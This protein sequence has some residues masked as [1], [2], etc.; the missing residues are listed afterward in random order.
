MKGLKYKNQQNVEQRHELSKCYWKNDTSSLAQCMATTKL[1]FVKKK[2]CTICE[3]Y[4][5]NCN[6]TKYVFMY[7]YMVTDRITEKWK[8]QQGGKWKGDFIL[9]TVP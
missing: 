9:T 2:K 3:A 1:Q 7:T 5:V 8:L 4:K 6:K